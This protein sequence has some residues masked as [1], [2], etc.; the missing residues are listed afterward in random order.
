M[1]HFYV[2][3]SD[4]AKDDL[5]NIFMY[6][7]YDLSS[8]DNAESQ[9]NRIREAIKK[10]DKF[11]KRNISPPILTTI[12]RQI[13]NANRSTNIVFWSYNIPQKLLHY[14]RLIRID[15]LNIRI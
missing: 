11:P 15:R 2:C 9:V 14:C 12:L 3:Y 5:R 6:I 10:L 8:R 1:S 13:A 4:E 7:A